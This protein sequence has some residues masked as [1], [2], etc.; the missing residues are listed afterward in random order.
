MP[1]LTFKDETVRYYFLTE[2]LLFL[3]FSKLDFSSF[4]EYL[5]IF[6]T[7]NFLIDN[8]IRP[9]IKVISILNINL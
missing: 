4:N 2:P 9:Q 7:L 3:K 5:P 6:N 1:F 8:G